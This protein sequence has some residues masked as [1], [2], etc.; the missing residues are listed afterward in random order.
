LELIDIFLCS[1]AIL[2]QKRLLE[3]RSTRAAFR[4]V[5]RQSA[6]LIVH[7][8]SSSYRSGL[9]DTLSKLSW[10]FGFDDELRNS[11]VYD[12]AWRSSVRTGLRLDQALRLGSPTA[13]EDGQQVPGNP[14]LPEEVKVLL[15]G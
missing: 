3:K 5:E 9:T 4:K 13:N 6:S 8:G 11:Q 12:R 10:I 14:E 1:N 2:E 15:L 7:R